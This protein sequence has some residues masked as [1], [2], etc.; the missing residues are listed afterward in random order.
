MVSFYIFRATWIC[1]TRAPLHWT[2]LLSSSWAVVR[3]CD[4]LQGLVDDTV[5]TFLNSVFGKRSSWEEQRPVGG[6]HRS[7]H[8]TFQREK[9]CG[10]R[11]KTAQRSWQQ[12]RQSN[13]NG[14]REL[15]S[16]FK[17]RRGDYTSLAGNVCY[18][19]LNEICA[20]QVISATLL[21]IYISEFKNIE[22]PQLVH[23]WK[24]ATEFQTPSF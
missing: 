3:E 2:Y 6:K 18:I 24:V 22:P 17:F 10:L 20:I 23:M 1:V 7:G 13:T 9:I 15:V 4:Y 12:H 21:L 5:T 11:P 16:N 19:N 8:T 14:I